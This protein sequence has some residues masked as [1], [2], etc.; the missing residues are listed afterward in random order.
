MEPE[1]LAYSIRGACRALGCGRSKLYQMIGIGQIKAKKMGTKT[2]IPHSE[3][4]H[5]VD[6]LPAADIGRPAKDGA[7][8]DEPGAAA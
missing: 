2:V 7:P 3:L 4:V 5:L 8:K 1:V 6:S